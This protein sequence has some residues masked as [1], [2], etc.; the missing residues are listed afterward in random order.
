M[1]NEINENELI[2]I[3]NEGFQDFRVGSVNLVRKYFFHLFE[4]E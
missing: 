4:D 1:V 2:F 3:K